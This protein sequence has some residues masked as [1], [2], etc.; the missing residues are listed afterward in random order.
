MLLAN[1]VHAKFDLMMF[2]NPRSTWTWCLLIRNGES[3]HAAK[4]VFARVLE[5]RREFIERE[6]RKAVES[7]NLPIHRSRG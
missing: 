6:I 5:F 1:V 7:R 2:G 3:D 4:E